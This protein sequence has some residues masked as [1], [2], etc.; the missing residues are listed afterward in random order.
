M[1][2]TDK[3]YQQAI[4]EHVLFEFDENSYIDKNADAHNKLNYQ[5]PNCDG[6]NNSIIPKFVVK[7]KLMLQ[8]KQLF[9]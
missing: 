2:G 6:R 4:Q 7:L 1:D 8:Y 5:L 9:I 3:Y